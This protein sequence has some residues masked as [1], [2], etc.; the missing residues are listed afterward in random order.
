MT[1]NEIMIEIIDRLIM[2]GLS[3]KD[4][5][6]LISTLLQKVMTAEELQD[7]ILENRLAA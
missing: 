1:F 2:S 3:E 4:A 6:C 5:V 7:M